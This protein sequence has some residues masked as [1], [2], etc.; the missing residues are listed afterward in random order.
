M[1]L[2]KIDVI[3]KNYWQVVEPTLWWV[4]EEEGR[5]F[6]DGV[7]NLE[8]KGEY[9]VFVANYSGKVAINIKSKGV[10]VKILGLYYGRNED[11]FKLE[12]IQNHEQGE[13]WSDLLVKGVF[14][15]RSKFVYKGLIKIHKGAQQTHAYQKNQNLVLSDR[16]KVESDPFLEIEAND[17]FCTHGSTT[18]TLPEDQLYYLQTRGLEVDR[19]KELIVSGFL[20]EVIERLKE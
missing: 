13:S 5:V 6:K 10:K 16:V 2:G 20:N 18:S 8:N 7:I 19:A 1:G 15:E 11:E 17:V 9:V 12:T 4:G 14:D 3:V